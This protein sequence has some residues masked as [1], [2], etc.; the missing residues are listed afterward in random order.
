MKKRSLVLV[1]IMLLVF[2]RA[3]SYSDEVRENFRLFA[4]P[5]DVLVETSSPEDD[6]VV[7]FS[8]FETSSEWKG[9]NGGGYKKIGH[10]SSGNV[11]RFPRDWLYT[12]S[13]RGRS[14]VSGLI[15][16]PKY[17]QEDFFITTSRKNDKL[18]LK[19]CFRSHFS[20]GND[21]EDFDFDSVPVIKRKLLTFDEYLVELKKHVELPGFR[22][23]NMKNS[24]RALSVDDKAVTVVMD[25]ITYCISNDYEFF[26]YWKKKKFF[27]NKISKYK[28]ERVIAINKYIK[29]NL[30]SKNVSY[31]AE[32]GMAESGR[33]LVDYRSW[34]E[35]G[36]ELYGDNDY[37]TIN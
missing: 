24:W 15:V 12:F 1:V 26:H 13:L 4:G 6:V 30:E 9:W 16:H 29:A 34:I 5:F 17:L 22:Y 31:F 36:I 7:S 32:Q 2:V 37:E 25:K 14:D 19:V 27:E 20:D 21:C 18:R 3:I 11:V 23:R 10:V 35:S 8:N 33:S 28:M